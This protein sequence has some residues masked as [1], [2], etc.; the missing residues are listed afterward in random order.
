MLLNCGHIWS[1]VRVSG[2]RVDA[3]DTQLKRCNGASLLVCIR[4]PSALIRGPRRRPLRDNIRGAMK[5]VREYRNQVK[6]LK[7]VSRCSTFRQLLGFEWPKLENFYWEDRCLDMTSHGR[8]IDGE[9]PRLRY[10]SLKTG[11]KWP[12]TVAKNLTTLKLEGPMD[13][14]LACFTDL[15]QRN[16]SLVSL[17]IIDV[18]VLGSPGPHQGKPIDLPHL[19]ELSVCDASKTCGSA[20]ALLCLPS[21][22]CLMGF[23]KTR[24][25]FWQESPWSRFCSRL[26]F[27]NLE[28]R[29]HSSSRGS[30]EVIGSD[31]SHA[32]SLYLQ[33]FLHGRV[34][35]S[36]TLFK[37]LYNRSLSSVTSF[38]FIKNMPEKSMSSE[39]VSA[40]GDLLKYLWRAERM[41]LCPTRLVF[42]VLHRLKSDPG[43]CPGLRELEVVVTDTAVEK[44]MGLGG[45]ALK[46]RAAAGELEM[47]ETE[48]LSPT[49][50]QYGI[51]LRT[52]VVWKKVK[53]NSQDAYY[54]LK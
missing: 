53:A 10:L 9:L 51:E 44:I 3:V 16:T 5:L 19:T 43:L 37:S 47:T 45:R 25:S 22:K 39:Q 27:T 48:C 31:R 52:K 32:Q 12:L 2:Q 41:H 20:L 1:N 49:S 28:A 38:S 54:L 6:G 40:I 15:L 13:L 21:L 7:V 14:Q 30:V 34:R 29:Y 33:E 11:F 8:N 42:E 36:A 17:E 24:E 50:S 4:D 23:Y 26:S 46:A 18:H 35:V